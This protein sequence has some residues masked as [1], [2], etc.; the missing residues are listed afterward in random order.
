MRWILLAYNL[1]KAALGIRSIVFLSQLNR[2]PENIADIAWEIGS[3]AF[4][5][6]LM[7]AVV[8]LNIRPGWPY[9]RSR[10]TWLLVLGI[11]LAVVWP[12][13]AEFFAVDSCLDAGGMWNDKIGRCV[14]G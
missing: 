11:V 3:Y 10:Y 14:F 6:V 8:F 5:S 7:G 1:F 9:L 4:A 13:V 2:P 12:S